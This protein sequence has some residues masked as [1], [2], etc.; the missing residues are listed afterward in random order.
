M[1]KHHI[2]P[3]ILVKN[4]NELISRLNKVNSLVDRVQIDIMDNKFVKNKTVQLDSLYGLKTKLRLEVHLMVN[5]PMDYI[6]DCK[7][8][9]S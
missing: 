9:K 1:L 5:K 3:A 6:K 4:K 7:R 8:I 2:V